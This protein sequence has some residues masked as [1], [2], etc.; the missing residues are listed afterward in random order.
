MPS[1]HKEQ[2]DPALSQNWVNVSCLTSVGRTIHT[3]S[4]PHQQS[5]ILIFNPNVSCHPT[6]RKCITRYVMLAN[7]PKPNMIIIEITATFILF[8]L[9][10]NFWLSCAWSTVTMG[11]VSR[12]PVISG[13][14]MARSSIAS[15]SL[16]ISNSGS[17]MGSTACRSTTQDT[18]LKRRILGLQ[19]KIKY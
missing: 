1:T 7:A 14:S 10:R 13:L 12:S 18:T 9:R 2:R 19:H 15:S 3:S 11:A 17:S 6:D 5:A 8:L 16:S 4:Q